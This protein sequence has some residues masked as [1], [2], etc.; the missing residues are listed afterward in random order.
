MRL[1]ARKFKMK[2]LLISEWEHTFVQI[3]CKIVATPYEQTYKFRNAY[4]TLKYFEFDKIYDRLDSV[5]NFHFVNFFRL[6]K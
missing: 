3:C 1:V 4:Y 5:R 6:V 2:I